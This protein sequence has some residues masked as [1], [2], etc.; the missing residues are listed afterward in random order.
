[1]VGG[2]AVLPA[3]NYWNTPIDT[4]PVHPSSAAWVAS[5]GGTARL[6]ADWGNVLADNYGIPFATVPGTQPLVPILPDP[7]EAYPDESDPGPYPIPPDAPIEGGPASAGDRHVIVIETTNCVLYELFVGTPVNGGAAWT[8]TS[9][10]K[11]PLNSNVLRPAGWTSADAAG[12]P[13]FPGLVRYDEVAAGE[14]AHAIRFTAA[15]IWGRD[16]ATGQRKYLWPARHWSGNSTVSTRPPM[17]ARF[18]LRASFDVTPYHPQTQVILRAMKK[19]GLVLADAGSN[20]FFQGT[21]DTRW[22]DAVFSDFASIAGSNFEVVDASVLQVDP[23]S[24][25]AQLPTT[26]LSVTKDGAGGGTVTSSP[27]GINCGATCAASFPTGSSVT[28]TAAAAVGSVFAGWTGA[29]CSGTGGCTVALSA[30]IVVHATFVP[31][32]GTPTAAIVPASLAFGGQSMGTTSPAQVVTLTNSGTGTITVFGVGVTN[33]PFAQTN[34]CTS[35]ATGTSC[36]ISVTFSPPPA[37]G[38]ILA[39][40][41]TSG[42]VSIDT[43]INGLGMPSPIAV[44]LTGTGEKS[45]VTHY[46]RSILRREPD[47]QGKA[48]WEGETNR[49]VVL[50]TNVNE[51]WRAMAAFFYRSAEYASFG[52][53]NA[54]FVTDLYNTFFNRAPDS[55]GLAYWTGQLAQGMPRE[56]VLAGFMFSA[57]FGTFTQAI[58]AA[59]SGRAEVDTVVD[60]YRGLLGRLPDIDGYIYW[61]DQFRAAQCAGAA[62]V[63]AQAETISNAF[64]NSGEYASRARTDP[65]FVGDLYNAFLRRGG[66]LAGVQFW[67]AQVAGGGSRSAVRQQFVAS[68]EFQGRVAA[69][70]AQGCLP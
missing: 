63:S 30:P 42:S 31:Q 68:P 6:H 49:M 32:A 7:A 50:S 17:G 13:I 20:W 45:L 27:A 65:Q 37:A 43:D 29:G 48:F 53:D 38:A 19:Y 67:I 39:T 62:A 3:D 69:I 60:F 34:N 22:A 14:I 2:C 44:G 9:W 58:F 36:T 64:L 21:S 11:W 40:V 56:V 33:P 54:G 8:A 26:A 61:R 57:E 35:L 12:L 4:L 66:D 41:A 70:V 18:R 59:T 10:A 24:A 1:M 5:V 52:R 28:L 25:K 47:P 55:G 15:N 51:A 16:G 46:Y 23:N